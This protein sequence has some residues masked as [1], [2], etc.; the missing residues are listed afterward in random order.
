M[1]DSWTS[2]SPLGLLRTTDSARSVKRI[3]DSPLFDHSSQTTL[4]LSFFFY[5]LLYR[6]HSVSFPFS[7]FFI[8]SYIL[9]HTHTYAY[10]TSFPH[11]FLCLLSRIR[12]DSFFCCPLIIRSVRWVCESDVLFNKRPHSIFYH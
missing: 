9:E 7:F 11:L 1:G 4:L 2:E 6:H 3:F 12:N 5:P 10:C 8:F